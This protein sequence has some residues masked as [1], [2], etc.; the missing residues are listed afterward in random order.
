[1][2]S[3]VSCE[4][5]WET[6]ECNFGCWVDSCRRSRSIHYWLHF[7]CSF[8]AIHATDQFD[9]NYWLSLSFYS[10]HS[11]NFL[12]IIKPSMS[13]AVTASECTIHSF[14]IFDCFIHIRILF[15][16]C[17]HYIEVF[18]NIGTEKKCSL[19]RVGRCSLYR[20]QFTAKIDRGDRNMC[21][22]KRCS[23]YRGV[24]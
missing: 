8:C 14:I 21:S 4:S 1:M 20:V 7:H 2:K 22:N 13:F 3:W 17:V 19:F 5:N 10:I 11:T 15:C 24:H 6:S 18:S 12:V 16:A 23:L 9:M